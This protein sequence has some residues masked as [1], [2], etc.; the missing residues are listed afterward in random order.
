MSPSSSKFPI[1][2]VD[3]RVFSHATEDLTKVETAVRNILPETLA[4]DAVFNKVNCV[5]HHGN[6]IV[7]V[8]TK[9]SDRALLLS[10]LEKI[11][12][13]LSSLDKEQLDEDMK[14]RIEKHNLYLRFDKQNAF[15]GT[16]KLTSNDPIH[17]KIHFKNRKPDEIMEICR[18][19]GLLP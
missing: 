5:G 7:T 18:Q 4:Q 16:L 1:A 6:P 13:S 3:I 11:G 8:E 12:T 10:V 9:L 19:A 14:S 2:Y 15:L 17:L